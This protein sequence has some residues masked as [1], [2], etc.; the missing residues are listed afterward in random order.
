MFLTNFFRNVNTF[1]LSKNFPIK[2][3][4]TSLKSERK[5]DK[6]IEGISVADIL[7]HNLLYLALEATV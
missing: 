1:L 5:Q 7:L 6:L 3:F 2:L 4:H